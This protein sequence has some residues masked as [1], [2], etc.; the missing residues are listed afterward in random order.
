MLTVASGSSAVVTVSARA[1][2]IDRAQVTVAG[3]I[4]ESVTSTVKHGL[5]PLSDARRPDY[6]AWL[7]Q[8]APNDPQ[9]APLAPQPPSAPQPDSTRWTI[10]PAMTGTMEHQAGP[11]APGRGTAGAAGTGDAQ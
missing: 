8:Q 1:T 3:W 2:V 7:A 11:T 4:A 10:E 5:H 9:Q 6:E